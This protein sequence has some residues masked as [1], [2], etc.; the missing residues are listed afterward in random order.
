LVC[1]QQGGLPGTATPAR[2]LPALRGYHVWT[3]WKRK[4]PQNRVVRR[5]LR[6]TAGQRI[7][8][9]VVGPR[10]EPPL[11]P[12]FVR[13]EKRTPDRHG[14]WEEGWG[15]RPGGVEYERV[16]ISDHGVVDDYRKARHPVA[17]AGDVARLTLSAETVQEMLAR[18]G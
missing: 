3:R 1:P 8:V 5:V 9:E 12:V 7:G 15:W 18:L 11:C 16:T 6:N 17:T 4:A 14:E 2:G 13:R 10:P